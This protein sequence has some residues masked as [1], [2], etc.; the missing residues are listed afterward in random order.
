M[1]KCAVLLM[2]LFL[3]T[4]CGANGG[5]APQPPQRLTGVVHPY[6]FISLNA[7]DLL[8][9][10][11]ASSSLMMTL[12]NNNHS[13]ITIGPRQID[14]FPLS[15]PVASFTSYLDVPAY[16]ILGMES[17]F[18]RNSIKKGV[19]AISYDDENWH[20]TAASEIA[21]PVEYTQFASALAHQH[22]F[23]FISSPGMDLGTSATGK[24]QPLPLSY[25]SFVKKGYL[26]I[27]RYDDLFELQIENTETN[28]NYITLAQQA[29]N[30]LKAINPKVIVLLQLTSNPNRQ[31]VSTEDLM[32]DYH[33]TQGFIDGYA[34]TI[35]DA[36]EICPACGVPNVQAM[37][38]FLKALKKE[39]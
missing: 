2:L 32:K 22:G 19:K 1:K 4:S 23:Q 17:A 30:R 16:H 38:T 20:F 33:A 10:N 39:S 7:I 31:P 18:S 12:F 37:L 6:W 25:E 28:T 26:N 34:L 8:E 3:P 36:A 15:I 35:P 29:K 9:K 13:Y 11:G 5:S 21:H 27:A 14:P 24:V